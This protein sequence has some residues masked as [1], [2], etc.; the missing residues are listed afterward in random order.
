LIDFERSEVVALAHV[1]KSIKGASAHLINRR[2]G[3]SGRFWQSES[4]DRVLRSS[5]HLDAKIALQANQ[6]RRGLVTLPE[7]WPWL[8][9][10]P[11]IFLP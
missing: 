3:R 6:V 1:T 9:T 2:F 5:E 4:F 8:P 10:G 11:R 7:E